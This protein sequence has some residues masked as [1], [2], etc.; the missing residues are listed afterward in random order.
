VEKLI[1]YKPGVI[2]VCAREGPCDSFRHAT[3]MDFRNGTRIREGLHAAYRAQNSI[4]NLQF[5]GLGRT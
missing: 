2:T 4:T 1:T 5:G 3:M